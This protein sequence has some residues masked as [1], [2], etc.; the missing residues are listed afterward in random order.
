MKKTLIKYRHEDQEGYMHYVIHNEKFV[1]LSEYDTKK[2]DYINKN[3][4]L[5]ITFDIKSDTFDPVKAE[6][7][8]DES[9][10]KEVLQAMI[11]TGNSYY[12]EYQNNLCAI[13]I[14]K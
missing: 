2:I 14:H 10:V 5:E 11:E 7:N 12:K 8:T 3:G 13:I 4:K 6:V 1:V 9:Y